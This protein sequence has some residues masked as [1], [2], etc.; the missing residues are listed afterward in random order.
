MT[1]V[2]MTW[3]YTEPF[4]WTSVPEWL[5]PFLRF[6]GPVLIF[7]PRTGAQAVYPKETISIDE[8]GNMVHHVPGAKS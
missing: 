2:A 8:H 7:E 6:V 4:S 5:R 1:E 3:T